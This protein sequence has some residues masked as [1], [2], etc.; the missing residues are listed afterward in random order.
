[1]NE[2]EWVTLLRRVQQGKVTPFLGAGVNGDVLPL[3]SAIARTWAKENAYPFADDTD[4]ARVAQFLAISRPDP[5]DPKDELLNRWFRAPALSACP[6]LLT[7][8]ASLPLPIYITTNYDG[9]MTKALSLCG[10]EPLREFC[11]WNNYLRQQHNTSIWDQ[12][13]G[14]R[15]STSQP[16]VFH[17]HGTDTVNESLVLTEDDYIDFLVNISRDGELIPRYVQASMTGSSLLFIGYRL[18]DV[19]F[20]VIFRGLVGS[21]EPGLRKIS[22]AVQLEP[23]GSAEARRQEQEYLAKYF[24]NISVRLYW[25]TAE[26]FADELQHR[27]SDFTR[28]T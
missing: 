26:A 23:E 10:K 25:G 6:K 8:L 13:P 16:I 4:L 14:F 3:G 27:W 15:P 1:M 20:R 22:V 18:A 24:G 11:H 2:Q 19:T 7:I 28:A 21:M 12:Q 9:L 17:L 5:M